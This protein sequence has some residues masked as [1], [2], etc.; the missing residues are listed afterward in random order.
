MKK[1]ITNTFR[2]ALTFVLMANFA[3]TALA[4]DPIPGIDVRLKSSTGKEYMAKT[5]ADGKFTV[6]KLPKGTY[7]VS[8]RCIDGTCAK[9]TAPRDAASGL[10][11]GKR[12]NTSTNSPTEGKVSLNFQKIEFEYTVKSP[13]DAAS[14]QATGKRQHKPITI[15][16]DW[17]ATQSFTIDEDASSYTGHVTLMK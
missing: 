17:S 4:G 3:L 1:F 5:G 10:A 8:V 6:D 11:T 14:G 9:V 13:R 2:L 7:T 16:K 12:S 15:T